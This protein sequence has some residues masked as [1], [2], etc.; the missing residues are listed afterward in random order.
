MTCAAAGPRAGGARGCWTA[1]DLR[2]PLTNMLGRL[3]LIGARLHRA[4]GGA[5]DP[6]WLRGQ[7]DSAAASTQR[8]LGTVNELG[9]MARLQAGEVLELDRAPVNLGALTHAAVED[10]AVAGGSQGLAAAPIEIDAPDAPVIVEGDEGWLRRV[11]QNVVGNAV[12]YSPAGA[13]VRVEVRRRDGLAVVA[14]RDRRV[15]IPAAELPRIF[16]RYYRASTARGIAGSGI[17]LSGA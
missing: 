7:L 4:D 3:Q 17:G 14:V 8:L 16:E 12:K 2:T 13:P 1:R 11:L 6:D 9:D 5:L 10:G 15:G